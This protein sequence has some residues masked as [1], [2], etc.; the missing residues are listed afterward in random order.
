MK[1]P[2]FD[3][4]APE[5]IDEVLGVL[6]QAPD[7]TSLLAGGQS[8]VPVLNMRLAQPRVLVDLNRVGGL[9]AIEETPD[10]RLRLGSMVRQRRLENEPVVR[11]R[12]HLMTEAARHIAHLA[13]RTRG[14]LGGSLAHA[15]PAAELPAT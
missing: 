2:P 4:A 13:I 6:A 3:Y 15:D 10:G 9:D 12:L 11:E 14:T 7:E 1:P 5:S 8:L